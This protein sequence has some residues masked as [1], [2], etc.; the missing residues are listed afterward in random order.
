MQHFDLVI[1][2][3]DG[4]LVDTSVDV[5]ICLNLALEQ[6]NLPTID[7]AAAK[8]AIGPGP[9][10][11]IKYVLGGA[12]DRAEEFHEVF[13][14]IYWERC[15]DHAE[16]FDGIIELLL[17]LHDKNIKCAAATNKAHEGTQAV[18]NALELAH[19][20][21]I[22]ISRDDVEN[23]KPAPDML[24]KACDELDIHP[25]RALMLGD[26]DNDILAANAASMKSALALWGFSDHFDELKKISTF[27][28]EYPLDVLDIIESELVI[29]V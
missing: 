11:F 18:L 6:M 2:D 17:E 28:V 20:F 19:H 3:L 12:A 15:A 25:V 21:D 16:P 23:H 29:N 10:H 8:Q 7:M 24:L 13:R 5:H 9:A 22:I 14:P 26:T 27:A 4:T 1:F